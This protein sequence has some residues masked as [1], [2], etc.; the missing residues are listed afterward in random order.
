MT[1]TITDNGDGSSD[2]EI[3]GRARPS[4]QIYDWDEA[5]L[6]RKRMFEIIESRVNENATDD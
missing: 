6:I 4:L 2:I 5:S 3:Y 1:V